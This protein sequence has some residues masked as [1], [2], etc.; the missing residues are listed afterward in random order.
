MCL[1]TS[2][3]FSCMR[4]CN[5]L[6][7][8]RGATNF[9]IAS[10]C[11][12]LKILSPEDRPSIVHWLR[13]QQNAVTQESRMLVST[14][15]RTQSKKSP[16]VGSLLDLTRLDPEAA[17]DILGWINVS[18]ISPKSS[19]SGSK[20]I[21]DITPNAEPDISS[22]KPTR[23][24]M[25]AGTTPAGQ[26]IESG[27]EMTPTERHA[28]ENLAKVRHLTPDVKEVKRAS[29]PSSVKFNRHIEKFK[30]FRDAVEGHCW[31]QQASYLFKKEFVRQHE[32]CGPNCYVNFPGVTSANQVI[33]DVEA[34]YGAL[35][36][37]CQK[38]SVKKFS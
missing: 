8:K 9:Y 34:L 35:Q 7:E 18:K 10:W 6:Q 15:A 31:K 38:V 32:L 17:E 30:G 2:N 23:L 25:A 19:S 28:L 16:F 24:Y 13:A 20:P 37:A 21:P 14:W 5:G 36:T 33:K 29:L 26:P 27:I 22:T 3:S 11:A 1:S 12:A 4:F